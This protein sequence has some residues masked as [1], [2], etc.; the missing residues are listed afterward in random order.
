[1]LEGTSLPCLI[2]ELLSSLFS[3]SIGVDAAQFFISVWRQRVSYRKK[4]KKRKE[5]KQNPKTNQPN[6]NPSSSLQKVLDS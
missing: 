5:K 6:E 2:T 4:K 1:M 3:K